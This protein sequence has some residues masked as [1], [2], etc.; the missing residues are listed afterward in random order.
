MGL[1]LFGS[2]SSG[3]GSSPKLFGGSSGTGTA[4]TYRAPPAPEPDASSFEI[5]STTEINGWTVA[6]VRYPAC[7]TYEGKKLL[8]YAT[9]PD[10][11]RSQ[12][13]LDPHFLGK[14]GVL[15]P[16]ARFEPTGRGLDLARVVCRHRKRRP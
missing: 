12:E 14:E 8:V 3:L 13:L 4:Q 6:L 10:K 2:P 1:R 15:S 7:P 9:T 5:L 16:V 11:V